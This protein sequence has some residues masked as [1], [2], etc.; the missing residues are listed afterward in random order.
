M[1]NIK[2]VIT[3]TSTPAIVK[4]VGLLEERASSITADGYR[5]RKKG[6]VS[7]RI[8]KP[9]YVN[10][11]FKYSFRPRSQACFQRSR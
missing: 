8:G 1:T 7:L 4:I 5:R 10:G 11:P 2:D 9:V 3:Q 6:Q